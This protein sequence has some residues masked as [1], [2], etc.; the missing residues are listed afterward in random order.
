MNIE[1]GSARNELSPPAQRVCD[2]LLTMFCIAGGFDILDNLGITDERMRSLNKDPVA[3]RKVIGLIESG[4][5]KACDDG[6]LPE[7]DFPLKHTF[8]KGIYSR[9]MFIPKGS[10]IVGKIH[11]KECLNIVSQ[12][13]IYIL[14]ETGSLL[15]EA[16]YSVVSPAG[17]RRVGYAIEDT[18]WT[19]VFSTDETDFEKLEE[20]LIWSSFEE[21]QALSQRDEVQLLKGE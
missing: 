21:M 14:T 5:R 20:E 9:E 2:E 4:L 19:N 16:P 15:V 17:L 11:K 13:S 7:T 3:V 1:V 12:G 8:A 6:I 10:L 18:V